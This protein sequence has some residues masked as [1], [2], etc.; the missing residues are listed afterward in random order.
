MLCRTLMADAARH[1]F[2]DHNNYND[3]AAAASGAVYSPWHLDLSGCDVRARGARALAP[4]I[5][6]G[7]VDSLSL[8]HNDGLGEI[9]AQALAEALAPCR[10]KICD[11]PT[12]GAGGERVASRRAAVAQTLLPKTGQRTCTCCGRLQRLSLK[13]CRGISGDIGEVVLQ[14][15]LATADGWVNGLLRQLVFDDDAGSISTVVG[16]VPLRGGL[17]WTA[18]SV[19]RFGAKLPREIGLL[20]CS[21]LCKPVRREVWSRLL[22]I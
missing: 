3:K 7:A 2:D 14:G 10:G 4:A 18:L 8:D 22:E 15:S 17:L 19:L 1:G 12:T 6:A 9:G 5:E 20:V 16:Y 21:Y 13:A 11:A